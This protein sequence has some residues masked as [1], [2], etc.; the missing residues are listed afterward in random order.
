[1]DKLS[2]IGVGAALAASERDHAESEASPCGYRATSIQCFAGER[3]LLF[4]SISL[5]R[6]VF[7]VGE[8]VCGAKAW[9]TGSVLA[10]GVIVLLSHRF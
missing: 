2:G 6:F 7:L 3:H 5:C 9:V 4:Q 8:A 1:M 10:F